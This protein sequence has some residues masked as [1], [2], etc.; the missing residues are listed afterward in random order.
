ML[1][2]RIG[3]IRMHYLESGSGDRTLVFVPGLTM[4]AG[5]WQE[6]FPYFAARGFRVIAID[7]RSHGA[8]SKTD[9]E[10]RTISR[11]PISMRSCK[12]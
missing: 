11:R 8:T 5:V 10:T 1:P 12:K 4:T 3:D 7:P 2:P 9:A 6:Q